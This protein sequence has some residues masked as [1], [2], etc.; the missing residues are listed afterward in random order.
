MTLSASLAP[1]GN[2]NLSNWYLT[3]PIDSSGGIG[4]SAAT[5]KNLTNYQLSNYF[6]TGSDGGMV[7]HAPVDGATT[8]GT[9][10]ARTELREM[11]GSSLAAWHLST[12]GK[13][14]ATLAVDQIPTLFDGSQ[15]KV[16]VGQIHGSND[17]LV[18]LYWSAGGMYFANDL[19]G[20][21]NSE[22]KFY[23]KDSAG[24]AP[25]ISLGEKFSYTIDAHGSNL[26]VDIYADGHVYTSTTT[27]NSVWQ[28]DTLYF[29]AGAYLGVNETQG[30]GWGET[31]FY[32][33][34]F[35]HDG[36]ALTPLLASGATV[37]VTSEPA[38]PVTSPITSPITLPPPEPIT[39]KPA[40]V[41][42]PLPASLTGT[43]GSNVINGTTGGDIIDAKMGNDTVWGLGGNDTLYG[44]TGSDVIYGGDG[45]DT[46]YGQ[47]GS[48]LVI[49]GTGAD[50]LYGGAGGDTFKFSGM[51]DC[52]ASALDII[53]DWSA[54]EGDK[55]SVSAIDANTKISGDQAFTFIGGSQF[56]H[57]AGQLHAYQADGHTFVEGDVNGDGVG[58][59]VFQLHAATTLVS[60]DFVL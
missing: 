39:S 45:T 26:E 50:V 24:N 58:D 22:H 57:V 48:D 42:T 41:I 32:D 49:G 11:N 10:Y 13:M 40:P 19:S 8:S 23:F 36:S 38:T 27:I 2:F 1:S 15:G 4:G 7:F 17:E 28:S 14:T 5:V 37:P 46:L 44:G 56:T 35:N 55:I 30:T 21:D 34:R 31:E 51:S 59:F 18:R 29:K 12:G 43:D 16:V 47:D 33:L 20:T 60:S 25:S 6:F 54:A 52:K 9:K 53:M 3:L